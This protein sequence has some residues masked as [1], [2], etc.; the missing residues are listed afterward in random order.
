MREE[1]GLITGARTNLENALIALELKQLEIARMHPRLRDRLTVADRQR[2][3]FIRA[4]PQATGDECVTWGALERVQH[5]QV[6][7]PLFAQR[8]DETFSR[9]A[10]LAVYRSRHHFSAPSRAPKCVRS[11]CN[12]VTETYRSSIARKS[13]SCSP[14]QVIAPPPIQ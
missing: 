11:R 3:V 13:E 1:H 4:M 5:R 9:T 7:N 2:R 8:L 12:G 10:E 6:A 14:D